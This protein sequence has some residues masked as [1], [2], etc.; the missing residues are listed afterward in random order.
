MEKNR[1]TKTDKAGAITIYLSIIMLFIIA[2]IGT[3]IESARVSVADA[4]VAQVSQ[5]SLNSVFSEYAE[6]VFNDYGIFLL[7]EDEQEIISRFD[8][9]LNKNINYRSDF[10]QKHNELLNIKIKKRELSD[11]DYITNNN[12]EDMANQIYQYMK[13]K[14][15]GDVVN[16]LL[17]KCNLL[18]QGEKVKEFFDK[19]NVCAEKFIEVENSVSDI[20]KAVDKVKEIEVQPKEYIDRLKDKLNR[21]KQMDGNAVLQQQRGEYTSFDAEQDRIQKD[22]LFEEFKSIYIA[23]QK[24]LNQL[25]KL[26]TNV[27]NASNTYFQSVEDST[28]L[29]H[30]L[31]QDLAREKEIIDN[32][33]YEIIEKEVQEL[34]NQIANQKIDAYKVRENYSNTTD[35][36]NQMKSA[37]EKTAQTDTN[38]EGIIY[39]NLMF[40]QLDSNVNYADCFLNEL[41]KAG[42]CY[43]KTNINILGVQYDIKEVTKSDNNILKFI[44]NIMDGGCLSIITDNI[45]EKKIE[46]SMFSEL[47]SGIRKND[48]IWN[49]LS[50]TERAIRKALMGQYIL[51]YF[52]CYT[53]KTGI[54]KESKPLDYEMEYILGGYKNDRE[55]LTYVVNK[56]ITI[57]EGFN[58]IYLFKNTKCREEAYL[59][60]VSLVGFTGIPLVIRLTQLLIMGAWAYAESLVDMR[61]LLKGYSVKILKSESDW[62]LSLN[63]IGK[64]VDKDTG[65]KSNNGLCYKEYLRFLLF[66]GSIGKQTSGVMDI[67][68]LNIKNR[69]NDNFDISQCILAVTAKIECRVERL[70]TSLGFIKRIILDNT[71][72]FI[73]YSEITYS[74]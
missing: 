23:Y 57:R 4:R 59:L 42:L 18:S 70:F 20:K 22:N 56:V 58:L 37:S 5:L 41:E 21:I 65:K 64:I 39:N 1:K 61:D 44:Q 7:W 27:N 69:Y 40:S 50:N 52:T 67:I 17:D 72:E 14:I 45:S 38:M 43:E 46:N 12:G 30:N 63:E 2:L 9:Y 68:Q 54:E 10:I 19:V 49:D 31:K 13:Y 26:L 36:C 3:L 62:N 55:N 15:A 32:E 60:A 51:D 48:H 25:N 74:Y 11:I 35:Y 8:E 73:F 34:D 71:S 47:H 53:D 29:L 66:M 33:M 28:K 6:E 24:D 16:V